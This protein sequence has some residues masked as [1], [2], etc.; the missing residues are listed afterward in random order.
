[1]S[2]LSSVIKFFRHVYVDIF[3]EATLE[4]VQKR[5]RRADYSPR[6]WSPCP[7][8]GVLAH[9]SHTCEKEK[10]DSSSTIV[11]IRKSVRA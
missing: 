9:G 2:I 10:K 1:M 3:P 5:Y 7:H 4:E 8:C 11:P 6:L